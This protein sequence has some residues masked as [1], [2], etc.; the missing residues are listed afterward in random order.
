M[1]A[2]WICFRLI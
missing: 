1:V 2:Y